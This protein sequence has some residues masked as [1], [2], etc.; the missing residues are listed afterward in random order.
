MFYF[1]S[2]IYDEI[3]EKIKKYEFKTLF[4]VEKS[5]AILVWKG[6]RCN[7]N[8]WLARMKPLF[9]PGW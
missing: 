6:N 5:K 9:G 8:Y 7:N 4:S 1:S 2:L 3:T